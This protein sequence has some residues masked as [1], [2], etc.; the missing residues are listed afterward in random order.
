MCALGKEQLSVG[1]WCGLCSDACVRPLESAWSH[2]VALCVAGNE[3][4]SGMSSLQSLT[5]GD[6]PSIGLVVV[7]GLRLAGS[8]G[9]ETGEARG[10]ENR[11]A[12]RLMSRFA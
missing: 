11:R 3:A 2:D 5:L 7:R 4:F 12:M 10:R 1:C 6:V 8:E 9:R